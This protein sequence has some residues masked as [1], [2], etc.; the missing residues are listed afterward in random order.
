MASETATPDLLTALLEHIRVLLGAD[1]ALYSEW[2]PERGVVTNL[3]WT[4]TLDSPEVATVGLSQPISIYVDDGVELGTD[5][6]P[7]LEPKVGDAADPACDE[8]TLS[9]LRRIGVAREAYVHLPCREGGYHELEVFFR[10]RD[11]EIGEADLAVLVDLG[12]LATVVI[13]HSRTADALRSSELRYRTLAQQ[14]PAI[15]YVTNPDGRSSIPNPDGIRHLLGH[16]P[17]EWAAD[18]K[19]FW[20]RTIHPDDFARV[21][22]WVENQSPDPPYSIEYRMRRADGEVI[23]VR[24]TALPVFDADGAQLRWQGLIVDVT[25]MISTREALER[26]EARYRTLAQQLPAIVYDIGED[27]VMTMHN[28]PALNGLGYTPE[29]WAAGAYELWRNSLYPE[30]RDRLEAA[31]HHSRDTRS[32]W[33]SEYRFIGGDGRTL[34]VRDTAVPIELGQGQGTVWLGIV[35]DITDLI[36]NAE[37][38]QASETRYRLLAEQVPALTYF[39]TVDGAVSTLVSPEQGV[40]LTGHSAEQ[41]DADP[42]GTWQAA[43]HPDDR[44]EVVAGYHAAIAEG[45]PHDVSYRM[46][47][48]DGRVIWARD[49]ETE[50]RGDDG[51]LL[52]WHGVTVDVTEIEQ[53]GEALR[54]AEARYRN[55]VEQ[56]PLVTYL[57]SAD[58][59]GIYVS[60]Q[61]EE[62]LEVAVEEWVGSYAAWLDRVHPDDRDDVDRRYRAM[63]TGG[64]N[65]DLEY[66]VVR[67]DGSVRWMHDQ[68]RRMTEP[69]AVAGLIQGVIYDVTDRHRAEQAAE[70]RAGQQRVLAELGLRAL[71]GVDRARL[72]REATEA[73]AETLGVWAAAVLE[74]TA[75]GRD[76]E[77]VA[78][79]GPMA[80]AV[81][82]RRPAGDATA[83][84]YT[85]MTEAPLISGD[86]EHETR[87]RVL[88]EAR[89]VG[90]RSLI[91]VKIAGTPAPYGV[92]AVYSTEVRAFTED[93][94]DYL[95]ATA[96]ILATAVERDRAQAAL[97]ASEAQR[98]RVLGELLRSA[99]AERARIATEL[100]DDT[101]QVMTAALFALDRQIAAHRRGDE[102]AAAEAA[103]TLRTTLAEA[104][105]R[106]RRLTFEL[107]PPLLQQRGLVA[108]VA[109][110]L[111]ET[112]RTTPIRTRLEAS[113]SRHS[114]DVESLCYRTVQELVGN[115]RKHSRAASLR[116]AL[117]DQNGAVV[118]EVV[119][120]GIG[121]D[122]GRALDRSVTRLHLGLDSAAERVRLAGGSFDIESD[123]GIGTTVRFT[124]PARAT[125]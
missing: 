83:A 67:R 4:G 87:F 16:S 27:D 72:V 36:E 53:S 80:G 34:W 75:D 88:D 24:D 14:L 123:P 66:R 5:A 106:T 96:N 44:D 26:S 57:D 69:A 31:W 95:Q 102:T 56:V 125:G 118:A 114:G 90:M 74:L 76:V 100:H 11:R 28:T 112:Q 58:G 33:S 99:D 115:V 62:I 82:A 21:M 97:A 39:R 110:L 113:V 70:R 86:L 41:W 101:I 109:E 48:V 73:A 13:D 19:T 85:L 71:S 45:R 64:D 29:E 104:V 59:I 54:A 77:I 22:S 23:W 124:L 121:F 17:E 92:L 2:E 6:F 1:H 107:R 8:K 63:L 94:V 42:H 20:E 61:V 3:A 111:E 51:R 12:R 81:G 89:R 15:V 93:E 35:F 84:G 52:G 119:D 7:P 49:I 108:A 25:S 65:F 30:D 43:L 122:V 40:T 78:G 68:G 32:A 116:V 55:L 38:L 103:G 46:M 37:R 105:E 9:Y 79:T 120:D 60:P 47:T 18:P 98:Q 10:D 91:C 117:A 50:V